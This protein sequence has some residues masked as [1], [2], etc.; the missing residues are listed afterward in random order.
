[1]FLQIRPAIRVPLG[2]SIVFMV[3]LSVGYSIVFGVF[4]RICL[5]LEKSLGGGSMMVSFLA[6]GSLSISE[7][8]SN[9]LKVLRLLSNLGALSSPV[10]SFQILSMLNILLFSYGFSLGSSNFEL[11][12]TYLF[13]FSVSVR[14]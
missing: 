2:E 3:I 5:G 4:L 7:S 1:M 14:L 6:F 9:P 10:S 13:V 11:S 8:S 12:L